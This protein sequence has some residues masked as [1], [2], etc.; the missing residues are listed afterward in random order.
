MRTH[1]VTT[2]KA[3]RLVDLGVGTEAPTDER[4]S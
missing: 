4:L 3:T 2:P 1:A